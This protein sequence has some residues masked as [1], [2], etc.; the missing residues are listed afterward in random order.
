[1]FCVWNYWHSDKVKRGNIDGVDVYEIA[2][3]KYILPE[4][5]IVVPAIMR[6]SP[7]ELNAESLG[8]F[9]AAQYYAAKV[10]RRRWGYEWSFDE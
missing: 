9:K 1:M 5:I 7:V 3:D 10:F 8:L 6:K 2:D 4:D